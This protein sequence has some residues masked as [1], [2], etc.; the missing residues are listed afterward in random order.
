MITKESPPH[1]GATGLELNPSPAQVRNDDGNVPQNDA[2]A[3]APV[4][5]APIGGEK[6]ASSDCGVPSLSNTSRFKSEKTGHK[7]GLVRFQP[8][9]ANIDP[10]T[11]SNE[12]GFES[13]EIVYPPVS[14]IT[15]KPE[16]NLI[17]KGEE[18][19]RAR[20][21]KTT[22]DKQLPYELTGA[23]LAD[24]CGRELSQEQMLLGDRWLERGSGALSIGP[25][26]IGK[27]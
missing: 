11:L 22:C 9:L 13:R 3:T 25:S 10:S 8:G 20:R 18:V 14:L 1:G 27:S 6:S 21:A 7:T 15:G 16:P 4:T 26:G 19:E 2:G 24:Y 5:G 23:N 17:T 12:P